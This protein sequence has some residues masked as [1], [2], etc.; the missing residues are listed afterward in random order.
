M[1]TNARRAAL[2]SLVTLSIYAFI[3]VVANAAVHPSDVCAAQHNDP[4]V[5]HRTLPNGPFQAER[6]AVES[7]TVS[8]EGLVRNVVQERSSG[9]A[10]FDAAA[11]HA[12]ERTAFAPAARSCV[13]VD[14][15]FS[16]RIV[17]RTG[18][19]ASAAVMPGSILL[20]ASRH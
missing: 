2:F 5:L 20:V 10:R 7:V 4:I 9:D 14:S 6:T 8:R 15:T 11:L 18:G 17:S 3:P 19:I 1:I 13:T 16:Y 12:V